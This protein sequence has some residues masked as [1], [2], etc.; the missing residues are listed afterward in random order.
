MTNQAPAGG[1]ISVSRY[2]RATNTVTEEAKVTLATMH[3]SEDAK[4]WWRSRY[5]D[6]ADVGHTR[7]DK[8]FCFVERLKPWA[9]TK[10]YEQRVQDLTSAYAAAERL[11]DLSNDPQDVRRHLSSSS[12]GNKNNR[13]SSPKTAGGNKH[14]NGDRRPH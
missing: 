6:M 13:P 3:L 10:L 4:L 1:A 2:F 7:H 8:V 9:K 11:F 14:F 5:V 12:E